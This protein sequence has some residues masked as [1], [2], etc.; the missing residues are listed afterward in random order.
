MKNIKK[1]KKIIFGRPHLTT[2]KVKSVESSRVG[3]MGADFAETPLTTTEIGELI[4]H[5]S[6]NGYYLPNVL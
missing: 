3:L 5:F 1:Q 4:P 2:P 6:K